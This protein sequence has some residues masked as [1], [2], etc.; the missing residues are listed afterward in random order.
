MPE[1]ETRRGAS[2]RELAVSGGAVA[3]TR[4]FD[5]ATSYVFYIVLSRAVGV[6]E[7]GALVLAMTVTQTAGVFTRF[8]LDSASMRRTAEGRA[9]GEDGVGWLLLTGCAVAV[10]LSLLGMAVLVLFYRDAFGGVNRLVLFALPVIAVAPI[11]ASTLRGFG[12]VRFAALAESVVQPL[13]ALM[14]AFVALRTRNA[15]WASASLLVSTLGVLLL[16]AIFLQRAGAFHAGS[17]S[18]PALLRLGGA[19]VAI[20][21]L[22]SLGSALDVMVLGRASTIAQVA[23]YAAALKTARALLIVADANMLAIGPS[24]PRL[25]RD[26]D[27]DHLGL[28]YRTSM[29]WVTLITAPGVL[30][31]IIAPELV[32]QL[33]GPQFIA[34]AEILRVLAVAFAI[35]AFAG[36]SKAYLLMCGHE[37]YLTKNA[38][39]NV[40]V[41]ATLMIALVPRYG[42]MGA[43]VALL[44]A[45]VIQRWLLLAHVQSAIGIRTLDARNAKLFVGFALAAGAAVV[46]LPAGR[47]VA[48]AIAAVLF[49]CGAIAG[50]VN[51]AD[52]DVVSGIFSVMRLQRRS[53]A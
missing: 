52:R 45:T 24:I 51:D 49:L 18:P 12:H 23:L 34:A 31:L 46:L 4:V 28:L 26:G 36:P 1:T 10:T 27:L 37:R 15:G 14:M 42:G 30:L 53:A 22:N 43:A 19:L 50:G 7:F 41:T 40:V 44:V 20:A 8:G 25:A 11:F 39:L 29:R 17:G 48:A 33:F 21:G 5:A 38:A 3:T 13:L 6:R 9:A 35:F 16:C 32:L 2:I 47:L